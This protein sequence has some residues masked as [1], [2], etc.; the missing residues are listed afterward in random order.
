MTFYGL[1]LEDGSLEEL[2][3]QEAVLDS[4]DDSDKSHTL[5][6]FRDQIESH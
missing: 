4:P 5:E 6:L 2:E 3:V 1:V